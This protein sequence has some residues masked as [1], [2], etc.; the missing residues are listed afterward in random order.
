[1]PPGEP[2]AADPAAGRRILRELIAVMR[3]QGLGDFR[4]H[5][6]SWC[7]SVHTEDTY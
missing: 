5:D 7:R 3:D 1:V 2:A 6:A 4:M